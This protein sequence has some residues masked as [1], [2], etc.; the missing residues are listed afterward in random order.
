MFSSVETFIARRYLLTKRSMRFINVIGI[1]SIVGITIGVA[2]LLVALS[3]FNGFNSVV[4]SVLVGFDPHIRIEKPGSLSM[5][6]YGKIAEILKQRSDV[7]GFSPFVSGKAMLTTK[8]YTK[9]V[10]VR[11]IDEQKIDDVSG[12]ESE[13]CSRR[14]QT[15]TVR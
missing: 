15:S 5:D 3:V 9:V 14:H 7:K 11:G 13:N 1:I 6:E 4:T 8:S 2:A 10:F 12:S